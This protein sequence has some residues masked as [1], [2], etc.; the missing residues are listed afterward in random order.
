MVGAGIPQAHTYLS[1]EPRQRLPAAGGNDSGRAA[2]EIKGKERMGEMNLREAA[3]QAAEVLMLEAMSNGVTLT[4][5]PPKD[6]WKARGVSQKLAQAITNLRTALADDSVQPLTDIAVEEVEVFWR[7]YFRL[8]GSIDNSYL[9]VHSPSFKMADGSITGDV[10]NILDWWTEAKETIE[11]IP[12]YRTKKDRDL[13]SDEKTISKA[14]LSEIVRE[15][16]D[17]QTIV[18]V[19]YQPDMRDIK[20]LVKLCQIV[21]KEVESRM[22]NDIDNQSE[23]K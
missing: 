9:W 10:Q 11:V 2:A 16:M 3:E 6:A 5:D 7:R 8:D 17:G 19:R 23:R 18:G 13:T 1:H 20:E 12:L 22:L 14:K 4:G 21:V 15:Y